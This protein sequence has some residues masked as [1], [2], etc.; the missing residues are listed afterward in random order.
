M[1][2]SQPFLTQ[3]ASRTTLAVGPEGSCNSRFVA[4]RPTVCPL[5]LTAW[6]TMRLTEIGEDKE[7]PVFGDLGHEIRDYE[8]RDKSRSEVWLRYFANDLVGLS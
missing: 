6:Y 1:T 4:I 3:T 5:A 2:E 7:T 8:A